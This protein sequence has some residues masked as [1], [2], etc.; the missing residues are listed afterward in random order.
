MIAKQIFTESIFVVNLMQN[1]PIFGDLTFFSKG[2]LR[3][4]NEEN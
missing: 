4:E 2:I 1:R 3:E